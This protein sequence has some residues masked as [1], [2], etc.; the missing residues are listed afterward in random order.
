M[1]S[2]DLKDAEQGVNVQ[3]DCLQYAQIDCLYDMV[4]T[5]PNY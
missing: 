3:G 1:L 4:S 2:D 5:E